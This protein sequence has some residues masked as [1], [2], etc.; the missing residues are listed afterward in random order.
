LLR[1]LASLEV[2]MFHYTLYGFSHGLHP[3]DFTFLGGALQY[4]Y[5]GLELLFMLS[6][7]VILKTVQTKTALGFLAARAVRLYPTYWICVT[8]TA[9]VLLTANH[10][11]LSV[12]LPQYLAN[13]TM[14][15]EGLGLNP[16]DGVY[17]TLEIQI[18]FY[19]WVFLICLVKQIH[20]A[21]KF[22]GI[23]LAAAVCIH[24]FGGLTF[25]KL[26]NLLLPRLS[27]YFI[28]GGAFFLI[29]QRGRS[30]YL[31]SMI[32]ICYVMAT[33]LA[34]LH[35]RNGNPTA[36]LVGNT[37]LFLL[38]ARMVLH[39]HRLPGKPWMIILF[40]MTYPLFLLHQNIGYVLLSKLNGVMPKYVSL[41]FVIALM[42]FASYVL[43]TQIEKRVTPAFQ[44]GA[45]RLLR[46]VGEPVAT[47][48]A[49]QVPAPAPALSSDKRSRLPRVEDAASGF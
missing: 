12:N 30:F 43:A 13:L 39:D 5:F 33:R 16:V 11:R 6:G 21:G 38:F 46:L 29:Y 41:V 40:K 9:A 28:A 17:W 27:F 7:F 3:L 23:W 34:L 14:V 19:A 42:L 1:F 35:P 37:L 31:L 26:D 18:V 22:L 10:G 48:A 15:E 36:A 47:Q 49:R 24:V 32:A 8:L 45:D 44:K 20:N 25:T 2:M 4:F